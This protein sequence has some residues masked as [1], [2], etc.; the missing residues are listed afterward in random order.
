VRAEFRRIDDASDILATAT[1]DGRH[2]VV[3]ASDPDVRRAVER[4]FRAT[5]LV[6]DDARLRPLGAHGEVVIQPGSMDW[7]RAAAFA[8]AEQEGLRARMVPDV[9]GPGGWDPAAAYRTFDDAITLL[10]SRGHQRG[11]DAPRTVT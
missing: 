5:A 6:V 4:M 1:W 10:I 8:R 11:E 2:A 3:D 9:A 7:F